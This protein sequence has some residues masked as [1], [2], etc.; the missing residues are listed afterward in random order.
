MR[1]AQCPHQPKTDTR[2]LP[3]MQAPHQPHIPKPYP[4]TLEKIASL[5]EIQEGTASV[6]H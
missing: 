1:Y 5:N 6:D 4:E 3:I 2:H